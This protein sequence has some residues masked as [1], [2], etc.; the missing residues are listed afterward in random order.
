ML[1]GRRP[2]TTTVDFDRWLACF[3]ADGTLVD[4]AQGVTATG[5]DEIVDRHDY[6]LGV[7][8]ERGRLAVSVYALDGISERESPAS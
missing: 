1:S 7:L 5:R 3:V 2:S 4:L 8:D 6:W